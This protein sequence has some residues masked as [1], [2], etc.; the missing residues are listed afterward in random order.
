[1]GKSENLYRI[2]DIL[3]R[4]GT[5]LGFLVALGVLGWTLLPPDATRSIANALGVGALGVVG[6][7]LAPV[8]MLAAGFHV[9]NREKRVLMLHSVL[10]R[11]L[12]LRVRDFVA[13]TDFTR[14]SLEE[15]M[16]EL[17]ES[18]LGFYVWDREADL[19]QDAR[20][21]RGELHY[22]RCDSCQASVSMTV[23][24]GTPGVPECPYFDARLDSG[25]LAKAKQR[26]VDEIREQEG[27]KRPG[28]VPGTP[29][30][31]WREGRHDED[32]AR[33]SVGLFVAMLVIFWPLGVGYAVRYAYKHG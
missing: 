7:A 10:E 28:P 1:M 26:L 22:D 6:V 18:G 31:T 20:L 8:G 17:N 32:D 33:F 9:R 4:A 27:H 12:E 3:I 13:N 11:Q 14:A 30:A 5:W 19:I 23:E 24:V 25:D 16:R 15:A 21:R 2:D 29:R